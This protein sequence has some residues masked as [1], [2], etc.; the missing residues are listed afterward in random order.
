MD[1]EIIQDEEISESG[2]DIEQAKEKTV[3]F[4]EEY[5]E[6]EKRF[7]KK[8]DELI[9]REAGKDKSFAEQGMELQA[10]RAAGIAI[11][12]IVKQ[13]RKEKIRQFSPRKSFK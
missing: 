8:A 12:N 1:N 9:M 13:I 6:I 10:N 5:R 7:Y 3:I 11:K 2:I 4:T